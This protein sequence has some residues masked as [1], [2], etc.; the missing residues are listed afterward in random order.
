MLAAFSSIAKKGSFD[1]KFRWKCADGKF[2]SFVNYLRYASPEDSKP[3]YIVGVWQ[4]IIEN[5]K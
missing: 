2:K 5:G 4:E 3:G 1:L